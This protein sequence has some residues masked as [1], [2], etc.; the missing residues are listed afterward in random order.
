MST[1]NFNQVSKDELKSIIDGLFVQICTIGLCLDTLSV[2]KEIGNEK[3]QSL[4]ANNFFYITHTSLIFRYHLE[5]SKLLNDNEKMSIKKI[6]TKVCNNCHYFK[7]P[8]EVK[9]ICKDLEQKLIKY[10]DINKI[11]IS[12][13]N[14]VFAHNDKKYYYYSIQYTY[15]FP[16]TDDLDLICEEVVVLYDF[17]KDM[18]EQIGGSFK[19][20]TYPSSPDDVKHLFGMKTDFEKENEKAF[21]EIMK[22][23]NKE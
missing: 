21:E 15:D 23:W 12:R 19:G 16:L 6:S 2:L 3:I 7:N 14:K 22:L 1:V 4:K 11:L 5:L 10:T 8:E 9:N 13:R 20:K 18:Q 17:A